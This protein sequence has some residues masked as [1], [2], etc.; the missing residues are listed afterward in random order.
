MGKK[1][2]NWKILKIFLSERRKKPW[3]HPSFV[4]Y[5]FAIIVLVGSIG[6]TSEII[7]GLKSGCW[8]ISEL[9]TN[10]SNIFIAL[11]AA[12]SVELILIDENDLSHPYRKNDVQIIGISILISGFL[13][14]M[15]AINFKDNYIG[16]FISFAGLILAY[17]FWWISNAG[18]KIL[19]SAINPSS[20][21]G[22]GSP[23]EVELNGDT[24]D[25]KE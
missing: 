5:F 9:T 24:T 22:N 6:F 3:H 15:L 23:R 8:V 1:L 16:L 14:W 19:T 4:F 11:I 20:T 12:S 2:T 18:N 21:V 7:Q 17:Y 13:L 25:F 10:A